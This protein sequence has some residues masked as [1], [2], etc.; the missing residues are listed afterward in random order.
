MFVT[1][2]R[3]PLSSSILRV[4]ERVERVNDEVRRKR[5]NVNKLAASVKRT[6]F[7]R[8]RGGFPPS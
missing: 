8:Y 6:R 3:S 5:N 2:Y 1:M 4:A 7:L